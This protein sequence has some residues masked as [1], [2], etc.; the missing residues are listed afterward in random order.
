[1]LE[2]G[3]A[4]LSKGVETCIVFPMDQE[5]RYE[6]LLIKRNFLYVRLRLP[7]IRAASRMLS[8]VR[9]ALGFPLQVARLARLIR[10]RCIHVV[11][12]NGVTNMGPVLAAIILRKPVVW[13]WNDTLTPRWFVEC[14]KWIARAP[15]VRIVAAS[16]AIVEAYPLNSLAERFLGF[17]PPPVLFSDDDSPQ[18]TEDDPFAGV[19]KGTKVIGFVSNLL[20]AKGAMEF[21]EVVARLRSEGLDV[22]GVMAGGVLPGHEVYAARVRQRAELEGGAV[23]LLGHRVDVGALMGKFDALLFPSHTEAAPIVVLQALACGLP[24]VATR[25]GNVTEVLDGLGMPVVA[26]GDLPAMASGLRKI[27]TMSAADRASYSV[28]ARQR[29]ERAYSLAAIA[30]RHLHI[31]RSVMNEKGL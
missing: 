24:V 12:V 20:A 19:P 2:V 31:Y 5:K 15:G 18:R 16:R 22:A 21:V 4:L 30:E 25:V 6:E 8:N 10:Q 3:E 28:K 17:L 14:V 9:F 29:V 26:V 13:H 1:M 11:H 27:I 7:Q 23:R